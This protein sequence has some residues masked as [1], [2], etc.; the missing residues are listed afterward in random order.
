KR[1]IIHSIE[2]VTPSWSMPDT[3]AQPDREECHRRSDNLSQ[4]FPHMLSAIPVPFFH[5]SGNRHRI[6]NV[7]FKPYTQCNVP[8]A[9]ESRRVFCKKW[10][11]EI[12]R[13]LDSKHDTRSDDH[14]YSAGKF[15]MQLN[16]IG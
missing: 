1:K 6:E 4:I 15:H 13:Q 7:F 5:Q 2:N 12:L 11:A 14:I 16:R 9:P 8:S 10:L 3:V